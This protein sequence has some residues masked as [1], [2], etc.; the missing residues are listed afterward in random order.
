ME[1]SQYS[2]HGVLLLVGLI[3]CFHDPLDAAVDVC[4]HYLLP[5]LLLALAE[6]AVRGG[7]RTQHA[8]LMA[9]HGLAFSWPAASDAFFLAG[10]FCFFGLSEAFEPRV[11]GSPWPA[12]STPVF[13][14]LGERAAPYW[15]VD[16]VLGSYL[17]LAYRRVELDTLEQK[18]AFGLSMFL[19]LL[20]CVWVVLFF[21]YES[22]AVRLLKTNALK[23]LGMP[24][25]PRLLV[26]HFDLLFSAGQ[27]G[28]KASPR[29]SPKASPTAAP[30]ASPTGL[31]ASKTRARAASK[32]R[33]N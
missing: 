25:P 20:A 16:T 4:L 13:L 17:G 26:E 22:P 14:W 31:P 1:A 10:F 32:R 23:P 6:V 8:A 21:Q 5:L 28:P 30:K 24:W 12:L 29:A 27:I 3:G 33:A 18:N 11:G 19:S 9:E 2:T 15:Q 7:V